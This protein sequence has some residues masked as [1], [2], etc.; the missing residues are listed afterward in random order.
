[1]LYLI[2]CH[3]YGRLAC[4]L[5]NIS[6]KLLV[7]EESIDAAVRWGV[8]PDLSH[9]CYVYQNLPSLVANGQRPSILHRT[10]FRLFWSILLRIIAV[11]ANAS[12]SKHE[13]YPHPPRDV[14]SPMQSC[15]TPTK[16]TSTGVTPERGSLRGQVFVHFNSRLVL[17]IAPVL[18]KMRSRYRW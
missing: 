16:D 1:M 13:F 12:T 10:C 4:S 18:W 11:P 9:A 8:R 14:S 5:N 3:I 17:L 2:C 6:R 15:G 7:E